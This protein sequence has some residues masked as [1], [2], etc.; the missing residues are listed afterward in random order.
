[1]R[2]EIYFIICPSCSPRW[3]FGEAGREAGDQLVTN[4]SHLYGACDLG[5]VYNNTVVRLKF[6]NPLHGKNLNFK[7]LFYNTL[8]ATRNSPWAI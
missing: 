6:V 8:S 2:E 4:T 5:T 7:H 1:V 3:S